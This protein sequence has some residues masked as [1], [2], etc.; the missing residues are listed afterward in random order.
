MMGSMSDFNHAEDFTDALA[1]K[2]RRS[3]IDDFTCTN[4]GLAVHSGAPLS[5][6]PKFKVKC[7]AS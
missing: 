4:Y 6:H 7:G 3:T 5:W 1:E 2:G